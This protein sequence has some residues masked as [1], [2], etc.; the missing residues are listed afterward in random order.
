MKN[1]LIYFILFSFGNFIYGQ[2]TKDVLFIGNSYT[3]YNNL[4]NLIKEMAQLNGN[5]LFHE[6][7]T[8]GASNFSQHASNSNVLS[9]LNSQEWDIVVLQE[10]SVRPALPPLEVETQVYPYAEQLCSNIELLNESATP[11]FY[12]TWGR[13]N[14][15]Q[16]YCNYYSPFCTYEGMQQRLIESYNYMAEV[17]N[18]ELAPVGVIWQAFRELN[19]EINLYTSDESHPSIAGSYLA[20]VVFYCLIFQDIPENIYYPQGLNNINTEDIFNFVTNAMQPLINQMIC[21]DIYI[22]LDN[23]WNII[24]FHCDDN[25]SAVDAFSVISQDLVI[26]KDIFGNAYL[27]NINFNGI[28]NLEKGFGYM[29]KVSQEINNF[30]ICQ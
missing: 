20:S 11:M 5:D 19:P 4:P 7:H 12:M 14:G 13:E 6:S 26:V 16:S 17:N 28:G 29:I 24:S 15:L 10:Q 30:N 25:L 21:D 8:P 22:N 27:P 18:A 9:L 1:H 23:G 3:Y 2:S